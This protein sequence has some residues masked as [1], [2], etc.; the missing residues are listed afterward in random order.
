MDRTALPGPKADRGPPGLQ[1]HRE[2]A[3][4]VSPL[5]EIAKIED[6]TSWPTE[7]PPTET[8]RRNPK[9]GWQRRSE[10]HLQDLP[11]KPKRGAP[12]RK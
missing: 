6:T 2:E 3:G 9:R 10:E 1:D 5:A 12:G 7:S 11:T 8:I 4:S